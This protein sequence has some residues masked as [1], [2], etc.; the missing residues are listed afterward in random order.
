MR[1]APLVPTNETV[2][3]VLCDFGKQGLAYVE[4]QPYTTEREVVDGILFGQYDNPVDVVAFNA[5]EG[6]ARDV[7]ENIAGLVIE[8]ARSEQL[9][10]P[11]GARAFVEKELD[12]DVEPELCA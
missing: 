11:E 3:M 5:S 7:S 4:T 12:E 9:T 8:R 6:W 10:L 2:H 1:S